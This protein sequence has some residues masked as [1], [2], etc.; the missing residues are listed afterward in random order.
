MITKEQF[1]KQTSQI[2]KNFK[3]R[4]WI[5][6]EDRWLYHEQS[7]KWIEEL[8]PSK[9]LEIGGLGIKLH[10]NSDTLDY[11][12]S[13][14]L[15]NKD[16]TYNQDINEELDIPHY[17]MIIAL[18]VYHHSKDFNKNFKEVRKHCDALILALPKEFPIIEPATQT[19]E[20]KD[21]NIYLWK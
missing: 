10:E 20:C 13:G 17:D 21:S 18:R 9:I 19:V 15:V 12:K 4:N 5:N 6:N 14:W 8:K 11:E 16:W 3:T 2:N 1:L 7:I